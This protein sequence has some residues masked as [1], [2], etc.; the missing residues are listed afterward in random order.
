MSKAEEGS[1]GEEHFS[2]PVDFLPRDGRSESDD[3]IL[4]EFEEPRLFYVAPPSVS[5][6][7]HHSPSKSSIGSPPR[8][9][10]DSRFG[11]ELFEFENA[12]F[13]DGK[14]FL[15]GRVIGVLR[16]DGVLVDMDGMEIGR[17]SGK[18]QPHCHS[19]YI[20]FSHAYLSINSALNSF[21]LLLIGRCFSSF[22]FQP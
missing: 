22:R 14:V 12:Y 2:I 7:N 6:Q 3:D 15:D 18:D 13:E 21:N 17:V 19:F 9:R 10:V 20:F 8:Q 11:E 1:G 5:T 16:V 4:S